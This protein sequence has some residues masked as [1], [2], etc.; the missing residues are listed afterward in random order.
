MFIG[1]NNQ[2]QGAQSIIDDVRF[3]NKVLSADEVLSLYNAT[4]QTHIGSTNAPNAT[5]EEVKEIIPE[6]VRDGD[7]L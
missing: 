5:L 3:Y 7:T 4:Y 2:G 6:V 1:K